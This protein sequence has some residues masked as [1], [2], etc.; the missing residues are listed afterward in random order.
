MGSRSDLVGKETRAKF[1]ASHKAAERSGIF[2]DDI[3]WN[4]ER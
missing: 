3:D 1:V 2:R 4:A